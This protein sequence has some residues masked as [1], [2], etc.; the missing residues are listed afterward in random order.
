MR[1]G[2][3]TAQILD[4]VGLMPINAARD[5]A[6]LIDFNHTGMDEVLSLLL[7]AYKR[8]Q[9]R[10][11]LLSQLKLLD[12]GSDMETDKVISLLEDAE[13]YKGKYL[14]LDEVDTDKTVWRRTFYSPLDEHMGDPEDS[15]NSGVPQNGLVVVAGPPGCL[16]GDTLV[17]YNRGGITRTNTLKH[18]YNGTNGI[19]N[20]IG[21]VWNTSIPTFLQSRD[22]NGKIR[23]NKV[24]RVVYSGV[25]PV[26]K[27]TLEDG[28]N[29]TGT[30]DHPIL[31]DKGWIGLGS[32]DKSNYVYVNTGLVNV[33]SVEY[34][35]EQDTYDVYMETDPHNFLANDIVVHNTGKTSLIASM[36]ADQAQNIGEDQHDLMY[37]LEMTTGQIAR[38]IL[39]VSMSELSKEQ[40]S[41][42]II[43]EEIMSADEVY[44]DAMRLCATMNVYS[45]FIDFSDLLIEKEEDE[46]SMAY[47]YRKMANLAKNNSSGS[48]VFLL[49][50]LNRNYVG[51]IPKINHLRYSSLAEAMAAMIV[52][53]YNP[54]QIFAT[55]GTDTRLPAYPGR[56]YLIVGKSRFGYREGSPGAIL[57]D[58]DGK[59]SWGRESYGWH[60]LQSI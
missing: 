38:R 5:A 52:L 22:D 28:K 43:C 9:Q 3:T 26:Y 29:I 56:G 48:P 53:I 42:V 50:Q 30:S 34:V 33:K 32:L 49:S 24:E 44:A 47:V 19:R 25:K 40:K 1:D 60:A 15:K 7:S 17:K 18:L 4:M 51:G 59:T 23:L 54:N 27:L 36:I 10:K 37:T 57:V 16:I 6:S 12:S 13:N 39:Q 20:G 14:R 46:Q 45:I 2:K 21:R 55:Q 41:K 31:T 35:G 8:E 58:F 11:V